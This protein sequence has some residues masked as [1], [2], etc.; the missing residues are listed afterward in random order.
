MGRDD[1]GGLERNGMAYPSLRTSTTH[2][3]APRCC[4]LAQNLER[5][6]ATWPGGRRG[7]GHGS[8]FGKGSPCLP[9]TFLAGLEEGEEEGL[10]KDFLKPEVEGL[11]SC[12]LEEDLK[13][14]FGF[15][16]LSN[17]ARGEAI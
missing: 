17:A 4:Q 16:H 14:L 3:S 12:R 6:P 5:H 13:L 8:Y 1:R 2:F 11:G 15:L 10:L 9:F 7:K